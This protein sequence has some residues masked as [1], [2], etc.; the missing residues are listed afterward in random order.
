MRKVTLTC[1]ER[2]KAKTY[3]GELIANDIGVIIFATWDKKGSSYIKRVR[4]SK[5]LSCHVE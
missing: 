2:G 1:L 5:I 3:S 4:K